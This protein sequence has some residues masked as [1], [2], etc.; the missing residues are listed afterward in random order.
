MDRSRAN[1]HNNIFVEVKGSS[2]TVTIT[3]NDFEKAEFSE[4]KIDPQKIF[5]EV[6]SPSKDR[7]EYKTYPGYSGILINGVEVLNYKSTDKCFYGEV[8][9]VLVANGGEDYDVINPPVLGITDSVGSGILDS[10]L[11]KEI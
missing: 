1:I 9:S 5:R 10:V 11:L 7:K 8:S 4:R 6:K 3:S 2:D